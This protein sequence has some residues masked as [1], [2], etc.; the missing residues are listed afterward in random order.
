MFEYQQRVSIIHQAIHRQMPRV[1]AVSR[2]SDSDDLIF[3]AVQ[4]KQDF[5]LFPLTN[6]V[7]LQ[8]VHR[9]VENCDKLVSTDIHVLVGRNHVLARINL[10]PARAS[11]EEISGHFLEV[12]HIASRKSWRHDWVFGVIIDKY[13]DDASDTVRSSQTVK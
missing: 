8:S 13:T 4:I 10:G 5:F 2:Q 6:I 7:R 9:I 11:Y 3:E 1:A 12:L